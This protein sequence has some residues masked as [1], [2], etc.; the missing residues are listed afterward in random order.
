MGFV[1]AS[2]FQPP[3]RALSSDLCLKT[4]HSLG[5]LP[6]L[7]D[8]SPQGSPVTEVALSTDGFRGGFAK[9]AQGPRD[10]PDNPSPL[11]QLSGGKLKFTL[12]CCQIRESLWHS[13]PPGLLGIS[14]Q[15]N[16]PSGNRDYS[17]ALPDETQ[18]TAP[19]RYSL[20]GRLS[21]GSLGRKTEQSHFP[22]NNL[23]SLAC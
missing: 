21:T 3:P 15:H 20:R 6:S 11:C 19:G 13:R 12:Q 8:S 23:I 4:K 9:P 14:Q 17:S 1:V 7:P 5:I 2:P 22:S 16:S 10:Y 18:Q